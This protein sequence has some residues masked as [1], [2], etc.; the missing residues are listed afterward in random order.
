MVKATIAWLV[1]A[2]GVAH[3]SIGEGTLRDKRG[4]LPLEHTEVAIRVDGYLADATV[5]QRFHNTSTTNVEAVYLFP[6]PSH[7]AVTAMEITV[8]NR[9][10]VGALHEREKAKR[11][12]EAAR[13]QGK[14]AALLTEEKPNLFTQQLANLDAG[15]TVEVTLH[16]VEQLE[17][18][19]GGYELMFP[20]TVAPRP[21][22]A[23]AATARPVNDLSLNV[24]LDAAVP[25]Q[26]VSSP[27][28]RVAI[29]GKR[30]SITGEVP[31]KDFVLRYDVAGKDVAW[32]ALSYRDGGDGAFL[33]MAQ[34]PKVAP[35]VTPREVI[36]AL[37]TSSS[38][39]GASLAKGKQL[40]EKTLATLRPDDTFQI[41]RF[42]DAASALG[43]AP[44]A[45]KPHNVE[46][47][48]DWLK[49]LD[50]NGGTAMTSGVDAALALPHDPARL[51][52]VAFITDGF[53]G[54][55]DEIVK[56]VLA[57]AGDARLFAF[58]VGSVVNTWLLDE[59]A[60]AGRGVAQYVRPDEDTA[61]AVEKFR[62]RIDAPILTDLAIDWHGL[63]VSDVAPIADLFAGQPLI[64]SG[65]YAHGG[66][67]TVDVRGRMDGRD[68]HFA[69]PVTLAEQDAAR[70]AIA[71]VWAR[72][73]IATLERDLVRKDDAAKVREII[74]IS[75][76]HRVL[77]RYTAFVAVDDATQTK[78]NARRVVVP[79]AVPASLAG[80]AYH[81]GGGGTGWGT[82]GSG[83]YGSVGYGVGGGSYVS[84]SVHAGAAVPTV[85]I[86]QP[87]VASG[88]LDKSM[89]RRYIHQRENAVRYCYEKELLRRPKLEGTINLNFWLGEDG[90]VFEATPSGFDDVV[91]ACVADVVKS[92]EFP[93]AIGGGKTQINYPFTFK[94][95]E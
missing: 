21:G 59:L 58:G 66:V 34:P 35:A 31:N 68:V 72:R 28:H 87:M 46:I 93:K 12:Y 82:I 17:Y 89:I 14:L 48:L 20:M 52:I 79:V 4:D 6:L 44:I 13:A 55:E 15:A 67:A 86:A 75:L 22:V 85:V 42:D 1:V 78:G 10:I 51:R 18:R 9:H 63:A 56:D 84:Y 38:M 19:D 54:N 53:V 62:A 43:V 69:V 26:R 30:I 40:I 5:T 90:V 57:K 61:A 77:T 94:R 74:G 27:S 47:A 24:F 49:R 16:Y 36:F 29:D 80:I 73:R 95:T 92:I 65:R 37:D 71:Q 2:M 39:R 3:A 25:V 23:T 11:I 88:S 60:S 33:L 76:A 41:V 64:V 91:G 7:A 83:S 32:G 70:P 50:A 45:N 81:G 8:G